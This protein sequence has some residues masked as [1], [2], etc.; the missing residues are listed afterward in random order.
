[1]GV[2]QR[3]NWGA[4][5]A[6]LV[7]CL[8]FLVIYPCLWILTR[9]K[10]WY[11]LVYRLRNF[12]ARWY[13]SAVGVKLNV[14]GSVPE[15]STGVV[16]C[17]NHTSY[18]DIPVVVAAT[19]K[20]FFFMGKAE[21]LK[22][23]LL[24]TFFKTVDQ[25]VYRKVPALAKQAYEQTLAR[26]KNGESTTVFPEGGIPE[27][28]PEL[29]PFKKGAFR[30]AVEANV[31]IVPIWIYDNWKL[32]PDGGKAIHF[33]KG[34]CRVVIGDPVYPVDFEFDA[35]RIGGSVREWMQSVS[36]NS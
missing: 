21:L 34:E 29:G 24:K 27:C 15:F 35:E 4:R 9:R 32:L 13:L 26:L 1:M 18:L 6:L 22:V 2:I 36:T 3:T 28:A 23:P 10:A 7:F 11:P 19:G 33:T 5:W 17:S 25:P 8:Q 12:W 30:M 31:P 16:F 20:R 14:R